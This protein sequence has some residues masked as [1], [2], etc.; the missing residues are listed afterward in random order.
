LDPAPASHQKD[1]IKARRTKSKSDKAQQIN[2]ADLWPAAHSD[3]VAGSSRESN[4]D[5]L[6][7]AS[8]PEMHLLRT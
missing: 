1:V 6:F 4:D 7:G 8:A 5:M 3:P 2:E